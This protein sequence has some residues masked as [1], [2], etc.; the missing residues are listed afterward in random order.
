MQVSFGITLLALVDGEPRLLTPQAGAAGL[1]RASA[2]DRPAPQSAFE[3]ARA[4]ERAHILEGLRTALL[5]LDEVVQL[6]RNAADAEQAHDAAD[7]S[8]T[9]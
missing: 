9:S 2:G 3:L 8:A 6:I 7:A 4:R 1:P 5:H